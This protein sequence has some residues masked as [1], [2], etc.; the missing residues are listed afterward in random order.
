LSLHP[1][2]VLRRPLVPLGG[3]GAPLKTTSFGAKCNVRPCGPIREVHSQ[4]PTDSPAVSRST[5]REGR[6]QHRSRGCLK[7]GPYPGF[8]AEPFNSD[9]ALRASISLSI[10]I[11]EMHKP[12]Q[13]P[14]FFSEFSPLVKSPVPCCKRWK[15]RVI[16]S[17]FNLTQYRGK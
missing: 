15:N 1:A 9:L 7:R 14:L 2:R 16:S 3:I 17:Y 12:T 10:K 13:H 6:K 4:K 11:K 5:R 8:M